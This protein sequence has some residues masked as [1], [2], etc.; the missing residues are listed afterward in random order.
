[1]RK[2][3]KSGTFIATLV[4][5]LLVLCVLFVL[6]KGEGASAASVGAWYWS[7]VM[8]GST[9]Y[10]AGTQYSSA[11]FVGNYAHV[12]VQGS[13]H[14]T[15]TSTAI[16]VPQFSLDS[17]GGCSSITNWFDNTQFEPHPT[18][19][20]MMEYNPQFTLTGPTGDGVVSGG[21]IFNVQ[22]TC[23][24]VKVTGDAFFTPTVRIRMLN[25]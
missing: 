25:N 23:M 1:M 8:D 3:S 4:A 16:L 10:T 12:E 24:R 13:T 15:A 17:A 22:G 19:P 5:V 2:N 11:R 9:A 14:L 7:T 21:G 18:P 20:A 6:S